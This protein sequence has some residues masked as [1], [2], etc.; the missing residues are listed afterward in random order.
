MVIDINRFFVSC[1]YRYTEN[2][3]FDFSREAFFKEA[4]V[5]M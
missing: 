4:V 3:V 2:L 1:L 5:I